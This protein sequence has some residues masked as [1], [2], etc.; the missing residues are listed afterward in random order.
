MA[1][2]PRDEVSLSSPEVRPDVLDLHVVIFIT[3]KK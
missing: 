3:A 2:T 1:D